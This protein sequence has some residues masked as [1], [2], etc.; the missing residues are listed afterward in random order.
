MNKGG[1]VLLKLNIIERPIA[2][3]YREGKVKRSLIKKL[4]ELETIKCETKFYLEVKYYYMNKNLFM[5][6]NVY[7][8]I[9][10]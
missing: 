2:H 7:I 8:L 6:C 5:V 3:K 1:E 10:K 9:Q 4:K